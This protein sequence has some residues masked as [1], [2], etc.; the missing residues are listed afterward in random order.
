MKRVGPKDG[1]FIEIAEVRCVKLAGAKPLVGH[2][3]RIGAGA[4]LEYLKR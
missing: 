3:E 2:V 4:W 1:F